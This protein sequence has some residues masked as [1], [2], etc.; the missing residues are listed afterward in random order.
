MRNICIKSKV[1]SISHSTDRQESQNLKV[2][3]RTLSSSHKGYSSATIFKCHQ[4]TELYRIQRQT[5]LHVPEI[6]SQSLHAIDRITRQKISALDSQ[7]LQKCNTLYPVCTDMPTSE[8]LLLYF[9]GSRV[10]TRFRVNDLTYA[11]DVFYRIQ[12]RCGN[13]VYTNGFSG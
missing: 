1:R 5:I 4:R 8:V 2:A 6:N 3:I 7:L 9:F 11:Y 12:C 13:C 10:L